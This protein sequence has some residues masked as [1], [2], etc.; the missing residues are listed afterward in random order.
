MK[1]K[2]YETVWTCDYCKKE[3]D[4]KKES[5]KH[6]LSCK[7]IKKIKRCL[8]II[9]L[10]LVV[11]GVVLIVFKTIQRKN[12]M[13]KLTNN[14]EISCINLIKAD[15]DLYYAIYGF[16]PVTFDSLAEGLKDEKRINLGQTNKCV[17]D[18]LREFE[19]N[20]RGDGKAVQI[21]CFR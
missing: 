7:K 14:V 21:K 18:S 9:I 3:F 2:L 20:T 12:H 6:E 5:D 1:N 16:Y 13:L 11:F 10:V 15:A 17:A 4:T 8:V 19:F